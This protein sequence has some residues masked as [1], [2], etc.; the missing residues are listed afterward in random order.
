MPTICPPRPSPLQTLNIGRR[1][2]KV[3]DTSTLTL[4]VKRIGSYGR[5]ENRPGVTVMLPDGTLHTIAPESLA[6]DP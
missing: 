1:R 4:P 3:G 6:V 2:I 5:G